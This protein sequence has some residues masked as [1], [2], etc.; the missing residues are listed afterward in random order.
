MGRAFFSGKA[1]RKALL[2]A[3]LDRAFGEKAFNEGL[4]EAMNDGLA[5][6][7]SEESGEADFSRW[8]L[9][10]MSRYKK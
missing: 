8:E 10:F 6:G 5:E 2:G 7:F 1:R 4:Q 3:K 9:R